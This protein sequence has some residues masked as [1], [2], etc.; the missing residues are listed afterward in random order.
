MLEIIQYLKPIG[1]IGI[2]IFHDDIKTEE[3][4][5]AYISI[6]FISDIVFI[7]LYE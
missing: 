4:K 2:T 3:F 5:N 1:G 6:F 7:M